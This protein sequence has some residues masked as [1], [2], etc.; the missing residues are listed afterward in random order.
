MTIREFYNPERRAL[1][2][3]LANWGL[4]DGMSHELITVIEC[5]LSNRPLPRLWRGRPYEVAFNGKYWTK[6]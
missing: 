6:L 2:R 3:K 4:D 5:L 1:L